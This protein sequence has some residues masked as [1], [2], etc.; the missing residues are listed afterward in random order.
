M[1]K[2]VLITVGG[3]GG[4]LFPA[5]ALARQLQSSDQD[6]DLLFLGHG[7]GQ[8]PY[9]LQDEFP[10]KE[11]SSAT[12]TRKKLWKSV[13]NCGVITKG[14]LSSLG[15][16]RK[17]KP[18]VV[19]GFGSYHSLPGLIAAKMQGLPIVLHEGNSIPGKV[20]RFFSRFARVTTVTFPQA[21]STLKGKSLQVNFPLRDGYTPAFTTKAEARKYF[22]LQANKF[23]FLV[24]GGSQGAL[25]LNTHFCSAMMDLA[26]RTTKFQ[27][28]HITGNSDVS[29]E[30]Q[31]FYWDLGIEACVRDFEERMDFAWKAADLAVVR[32]GAATI[33][34]QIQMEVPAILIPYP[35]ATDNHQE[36]NADF[37]EQEIKG[38]V[39]ISEADLIPTKLSQVI[40]SLVE[41]NH[42]RLNSMS[43]ELRIYKL[44][45]RGMD[46]CSVVSE[47][48]GIKLR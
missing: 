39:K 46:L 34:E 31:K 3:T 16:I 10:F 32:A 37:V 13:L 9:F 11:V 25:T 35:F 29:E 1:T 21:A 40:S 36:K 48:A 23:T 26:E 22:V 14:I 42:A 8:N 27:I 5:Q 24:F 6:V 47:V 18:D 15:I 45:N 41:K 28:L 38:A 2:K 30:L 43:E 44:K 19:V 7:L 4:H 17:Y 20:N 33:A 12:F